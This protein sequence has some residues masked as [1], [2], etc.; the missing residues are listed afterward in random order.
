MKVK[1]V[2]MYVMGLGL[3]FSLTGCGGLFGPSPEEKEANDKFAKL[4]EKYNEVAK[5]K[6]VTTISN[7]EYDKAKKI[8]Y[9]CYG[10]AG[11]LVEE[12]YAEF[13]SCSGCE[14][15]DQYQKDTPVKTVDGE[16]TIEKV[17]RTCDAIHEKLRTKEGITFAG[18]SKMGQLVK[19]DYYNAKVGKL[20]MYNY[21]AGGPRSV[22]C[23]EMPKKEYI[24]D[25]FKKHESFIRKYCTGMI[26]FESREWSVKS[27]YGVP[28]SRS[29]QFLC[30]EETK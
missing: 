15:F 27:E 4:G 10:D 14:Y 13:G 24:P 20:K 3:M 29:G 22:E 21:Y 26:D 28:Q 5:Y 9:E 23:S 30:W 7:L 11:S 1:T 25:D 8:A 18:C 17:Y 6:K 2:L 16:L 12:L 19:Q